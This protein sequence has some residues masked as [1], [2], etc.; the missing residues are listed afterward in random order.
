MAGC[1]HPDTVEVCWAT[2]DTRL[3]PRRRAES[4][5][6]PVAREMQHPQPCEVCRSTADTRL[7]P[8]PQDSGPV[9]W[10]QGPD[11]PG[12]YRSMGIAA[13]VRP[14]RGDARAVIE[15]SAAGGWALI[16]GSD[17]VEIFDSFPDAA[18][19]AV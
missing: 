11:R 19:R 16:H 13:R 8:W 18:A 2:A 17:E 4:T 6:P 9:R 5:T 3:G 7:S 15:A 14:P 1:R 10:I 12:R